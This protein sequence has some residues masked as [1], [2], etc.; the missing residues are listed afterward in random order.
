MAVATGLD[1]RVSMLRQTAGF[2]SVSEYFKDA[3]YRLFGE[4]CAS[5][6]KDRRISTFWAI[7]GQGG[8]SADDRSMRHPHVSWLAR[9]VGFEARAGALGG[10][11]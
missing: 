3:S 6:E 11:S 8:P 7:S 10:A 2:N 5:G 1:R 4:S 9:S